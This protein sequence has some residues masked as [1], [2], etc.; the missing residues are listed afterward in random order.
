MDPS[1]INWLAILVAGVSSFILGGVWYSPAL[2]GKAWMKE[3]GLTEEKVR[4]GNKSKIFG[5]S[6][7]LSLIMA[8]NLGMFLADSPASCPAEC[9]QQT[10]V[11]WGAIAGF[12]A[13]IWVFAGISIVA[14]FEQKSLRYILI[15][16]GFMLVSLLLM[17]AIIGLWR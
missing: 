3:N 15:N 2:F 8:V 16:G 12:L 5:W 11:S 6:L 9:A 7:I 14:L 10:D 4:A 13:G 1:S 17:G